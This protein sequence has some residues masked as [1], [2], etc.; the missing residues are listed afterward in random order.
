MIVE[1]NARMRQAL[2]DWL[3]DCAAEFLDR[4]GNRLAGG[5]RH[6][7]FHDPRASCQR[8]LARAGGPMHP[9]ASAATMPRTRRI[10]G[11]VAT[12]Q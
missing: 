7:Q 5:D 8:I 1:D 12:N 11:S 10:M 2:K 4:R 6:C 3:A 9:C